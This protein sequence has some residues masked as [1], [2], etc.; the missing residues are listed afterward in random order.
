MNVSRTR[1]F[2]PPSKSSPKASNGTRNNY[3]SSRSH[4]PD[5]EP[6]R[7]TMQLHRPRLAC[8][9]YDNSGAESLWSMLKHEYYY[10]HA[11]ATKSELIAAVD[12][13]MPFYNNQRRHSVI[14]MLGARSSTNNHST[15]PHTLH[16][17]CPLFQGEPPTL[18]SSPSHAA[19]QCP[20]TNSK[21]GEIRSKPLG[22]TT[23]FFLSM[24]LKPCGVGD[25]V[26]FV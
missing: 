19:V 18:V 14:G 11:F 20:A 25:F 22:V 13:W 21:C 9:C 2:A 10:R 12:K 26:G 6:F 23:M 15:R 17:P 24:K 3:A 1:T 5:D 16:N 4:H 7:S 8:Q